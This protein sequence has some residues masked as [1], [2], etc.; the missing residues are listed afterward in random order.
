M[1][2]VLELTIMEY[3]K[4]KWNS[5]TFLT[6]KMKWKWNE[7]EPDVWNSESEMKWNEID[8][9][10]QTLWNEMWNEIVKSEPW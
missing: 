9:I 5:G 3:V 4:W 1:A 6:A 10:S 2:S 7:T 8:H